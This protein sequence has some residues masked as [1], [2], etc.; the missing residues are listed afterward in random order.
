MGSSIILRR[1][2]LIF[3]AMLIPLSLG[4][5]FVHATNG[6]GP[7]SEVSISNGVLTVYI[8]S[9]VSYDGVGTYTVCTGPNHPVPNQDVLQFGVEGDAWTS[10]NTVHLVGTGVDYITETDTSII[11]YSGFSLAIL[12]G[13]TPSI[14]E[15]TQTRMVVRWLTNE[16]LNITQIIEVLG[17]TVTDTYVR[18]TTTIRNDNDTYSYGVG[19]RYL[20]DLNVADTDGSWLR[21]VNPTSSW[22]GNEQTWAPPSFSYWEAT[23]DPV[24]PTLIVRGSITEPSTLSPKPTPPDV[25]TFAAWGRNSLPNPGLYDYAW[26]FT[27]LNR[28]V[29]G[30]E[31]DSAVAYY[32]GPRTLEPDGEMSV[33][34][35]IWYSPPTPVGGFIVDSVPNVCSQFILLVAIVSSCTALGF[36]LAKICGKRGYL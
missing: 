32:W 26:D 34:A 19:I 29:A 13:L 3:S 22:L 35:Y 7:D 12:D 36:A 21:T 9:E 33:T 6:S 8:E 4:F 14:V 1:F 23:D 25:F 31:L 17:S 2:A 27:T 18:V 16:G 15:Q 5:A 11:P 28:L 10:Y 30:A 24:D 20:W